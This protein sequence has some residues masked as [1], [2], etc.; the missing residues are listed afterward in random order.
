VFVRRLAID[1]AESEY[2]GVGSATNAI[3]LPQAKPRTM[4]EHF[5][6][7]S[8]RSRDVAWAEWSYIRRFEHFL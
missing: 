4:G 2:R 1:F 5:V 7:P 8:I 3:A 6:V